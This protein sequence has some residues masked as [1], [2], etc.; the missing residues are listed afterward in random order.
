MAGLFFHCQVWFLEVAAS[1]FG[2]LQHQTSPFVVYECLWFWVISTVSN[3]GPGP[4]RRLV[5]TD[6]GLR[7][8]ASW[9]QKHRKSEMNDPPNCSLS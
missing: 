5:Q 7:Q 8:V 4:C 1:R 3:L 6:P 2:Q 9:H